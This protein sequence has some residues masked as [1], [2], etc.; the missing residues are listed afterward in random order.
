[1]ARYMDFL[2]L[3]LD[4]TETQKKVDTWNRLVA[5]GKDSLKVVAGARTEII[6]HRRSSWF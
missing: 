1:M 3:Q 6:L 4:D 2:E 5:K